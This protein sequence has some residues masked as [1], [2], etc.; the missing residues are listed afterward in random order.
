[1][2]QSSGLV[3]GASVQGLMTFRHR[4]RR[5]AWKAALQEVCVQVRGTER[6]WAL[7]AASPK[8][9]GGGGARRNGCLQ[10]PR[11][12]A[13]GLRA[14]RRC[15]RGSRP[16][17]HNWTHTPCVRAAGGP[18]EPPGGAPRTQKAPPTH[19]HLVEGVVPERGREVLREEVPGVGAHDGSHV[20]ARQQLRPGIDVGVGLERVALEQR[21]LLGLAL[22]ARGRRGALADAA[23]LDQLEAGSSAGRHLAKDR[24]VGARAVA[25]PQ[26]RLRGGGGRRR[27]V[28][29]GAAGEQRGACVAGSSGK[30]KQR[31]GASGQGGRAA[32]QQ[33]APW[34]A[35]ARTRARAG[36]CGTTGRSGPRA[37]GPRGADPTRAPAPPRA[38]EEPATPPTHMPPPP[39][40]AGRPTSGRSPARRPCLAGA[41]SGVCQR[42]GYPQ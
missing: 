32:P 30:G 5:S 27:R 10:A 8:G 22:G 12:T 28:G 14:C 4:A 18:P 23:L 24:L 1:M 11:P 39:A 21:A 19:T 35:L 3:P 25:V 38:P 29:C 33:A 9:G 7:A 2:E 40:T 20:S 26:Q 6:G 17:T 34:A 37:A 42:T 41:R 13:R 36:G 31:R 16:P 15:R